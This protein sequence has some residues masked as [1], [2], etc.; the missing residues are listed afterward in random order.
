MADFCISKVPY[1]TERTL[2]V[3]VRVHED[4]GDSLGYPKDWLRS[5]I[6]YLL[7]NGKNFLTVFKEDNN[8]IKGDKVRIK[9]IKG[10]EYIK[11]VNDSVTMGF[12]YI[13]RESIPK[14][15]LMNVPDLENLFIP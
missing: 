3:A 15:D 6:L 5:G 13:E 7:N 4:L 1:N 8:W 12:G 11:T 14:D 10:F 2:I 9:Y